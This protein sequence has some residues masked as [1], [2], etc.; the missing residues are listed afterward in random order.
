MNTVVES[1]ADE[2]PI[3]FWVAGV[4]S[5]IDPIHLNVLSQQQREAV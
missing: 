2:E 4:P 5:G 1:I 3:R